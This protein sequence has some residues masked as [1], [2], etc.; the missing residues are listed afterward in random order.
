MSEVLSQSEIDKLFAQM[1]SGELDVQNIKETAKEKVIKNYD[2]ARPSKFSKD[3]LRTLEIIF[4]NYARVISNYLSAYLRTVVPIEVISAEALTF[5]EFNNSLPNPLLL[6]VVDAKPLKGSI[7]IEMAPGLGFSIIDKI[8]GGK[9]A[10]IPKIREFTNIERVI[11]NKVFE[12]FAAL[13]S[14]PWRNVIEINSKLEK[15]ETNPQVVQIIS[16]SEMIALITLNVTLGKTQGMINVCIPHLVLEPIMDRLNTKHWF[17]HGIQH[18]E[19]DSKSVDVQKALEETS[20]PVRAVLGEASV[21][22]I[23]IL[24]LS[25]GD[26][27]RLNATTD[28]DIKVFVG[29]TCRFTASPGC[30]QNKKAIRINTV[31]KREEQA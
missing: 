7:I 19:E 9:G 18:A 25:K 10:P 1:T 30:K 20:I 8:L 3:H 26:I 21:T 5:H 31:I 12:Q 22:A 24:N 2:F 27:L 23:D 28:S 14:E 15:L 13:L 29:S 17:T 6:G 16:P 11:L 4:E